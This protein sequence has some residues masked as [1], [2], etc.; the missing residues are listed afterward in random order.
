MI[1]AKE[2]SPNESQTASCPTPPSL[3]T[4]VHSSV[5]GTPQL[6]RDWLMSSQEGSPASPSPLQESE[7]AQTT[8]AICGPQQQ[9][10]YAL[11]DH[12]TA[13]LRT[14][15]A[16]LIADT[17]GASSLTWPRAGMVYCGACYRQPNWE[18]PIS[19]SA[20]GL[21]PTPRAGKVSSE[22]EESWMKRYEAG[23]VQTPPLALAVKMWPTPTVD[24]AKNTSP[25][26]SN[27]YHTLQKAVGGALNP[28]WVGWLMGMPVGWQS[29]KPLAMHRFQSWLQQHGDY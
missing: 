5:K 17:L 19:A 1:T 29:L 13:S 14:S 28:M 3:A 22:N 24:D 2:L 9:S 8:P 27:H 26:R 11:F 7:Q 23:K 15:Q 16:Y 12:D 4:S 18:R 6:I 21:W 10:V 20:S 25:N